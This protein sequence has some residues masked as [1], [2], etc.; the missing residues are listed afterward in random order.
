MNIEKLILPINKT[1]AIVTGQR[2]RKERIVMNVDNRGPYAIEVFDEIIRYAKGAC[3]IERNGK[4][5]ILSNF[6]NE[7]VLEQNSRR[8]RSFCI[9]FEIR[10]E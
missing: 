5:L 1:A 10:V 4:L 8:I 2:K 9:P 6:V 3:K 7:I